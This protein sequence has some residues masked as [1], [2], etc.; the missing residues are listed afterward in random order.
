MMHNE[1]LMHYGVPGMKWGVRKRYDRPTGTS[2]SQSVSKKKG[3]SKRQKRM[4]KIGAA[5]VGTALVIAGG[6]KLGVHKKVANLA[7]TGLSA[8]KSKNTKLDLSSINNTSQLLKLSLSTI[9]KP[10]YSKPS[11][12][13]KK[14]LSGN[15]DSGIVL[16]FGNAMSGDYG[17]TTERAKAFLNSTRLNQSYNS[18]KMNK[19][20]ND[21]DD[22]T[23][24]LLRKNEVLLNRR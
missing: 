10:M 24:T 14:S 19:T 23:N 1:Y 13:P 15:K 2:N 3:L 7:K 11:T 6:Y 16:T 21:I 20:F 17:K 4:L 8:L 12:P 18:A 5:S 9:N 22:F